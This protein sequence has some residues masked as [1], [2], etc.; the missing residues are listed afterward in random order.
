MPLFEYQCRSCGAEIELLVMG[1]S[2][3]V[4]SE[5][6]SDDLKK[7][8]SGFAVLDARSDCHACGCGGPDDCIG[9]RAAA[10]RACGKAP[11]C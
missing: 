1:S 2:Q 7:L 6:G 11:C 5:C 10:A 3:P 4:C 8:L 9:N